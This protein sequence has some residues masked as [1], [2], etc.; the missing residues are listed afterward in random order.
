[1][2]KCKS[3]IVWQKKFI[4]NND[5]YFNEKLQTK[6]IYG[7]CRQ[8]EFLIKND[9]EWPLAVVDRWPLFTEKSSIDFEWA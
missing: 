8:V 4:Q 6:L 9:F 2:L 5:F 7:P 1:M 3:K